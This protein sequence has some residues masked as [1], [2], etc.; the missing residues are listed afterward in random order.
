MAPVG[1]MIAGPVADRLGIQAWFLLG[2]SLCVL[3][4]IAGLFVPAVMNIEQK[5]C[6][7][8]VQD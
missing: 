8:P 6:P 5:R 2:G 3:M 1:L 4:S 7:A